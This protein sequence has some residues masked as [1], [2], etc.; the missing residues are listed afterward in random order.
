M[1]TKAFAD[2]SHRC[3]VSLSETESQF[4][5]TVTTEL[6]CHLTTVSG[7]SLLCALL[8]SPRLHFFIAVFDTTGALPILS[9][10]AVALHAIP[11]SPIEATSPLDEYQLSKVTSDLSQSSTF[12][13]RS[14]TTRR[15]KSFPDVPGPAEPVFAPSYGIIW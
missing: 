2:L 10:R 15:V 11:R 14:Y 4:E 12:S 5:R 8:I 6:S 1:L 9:V 3:T 7:N 13:K